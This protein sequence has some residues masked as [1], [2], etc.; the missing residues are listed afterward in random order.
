MGT[1]SELGK[2]PLFEERPRAMPRRLEKSILILRYAPSRD[3]GGIETVYRENSRCGTYNTIAD[4]AIR[5]IQ[6][7]GIGPSRALNTRL[8][9]LILVSAASL[10]LEI[11]ETKVVT[12]KGDR[13]RDL[14]LCHIVEGTSTCEYA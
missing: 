5:N 4:I 9:P 3:Y 10:F 13:P 1:S 8:L 7:P 6:Q 2:A 12:I 11:L 14:E